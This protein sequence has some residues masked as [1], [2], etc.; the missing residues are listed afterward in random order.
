MTKLL[1]KSYRKIMEIEH[2]VNDGKITFTNSGDY[3]PVKILD[4]LQRDVIKCEKLKPSEYAGLKEVEYSVEIDGEK[5]LVPKE[6]IEDIFTVKEA[7]FKNLDELVKMPETKFES[8][9]FSDVNL[10]HH[11]YSIYMTSEML[12]LA[13]LGAKLEIGIIKPEATFVSIDSNGII[14]PEDKLV[15]VNATIDTNDD[16]D[17]SDLIEEAKLCMVENWMLK[18]DF[19]DKPK[20]EE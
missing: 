1:I 15:I 10:N 4:E 7:H 6:I 12:K 3:L 11:E 18:E 14:E 16:I 20:V 19:P 8:S 5:Y 9:I 2:T 17:Y 13:A